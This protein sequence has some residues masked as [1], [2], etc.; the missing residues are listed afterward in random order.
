MMPESAV[1]SS[2]IREWVISVSSHSN[3]SLSAKLLHLGP[4]LCDPVNC[5]LPGSFVCGILQARTLE[6]VA[7]PSSRGSSWPRGQTSIFLLLLHWQVGSLPPAPPYCYHLVT[8]LCLTLWPHGLHAAHQAS[9]SFT[10]SWNLLKLMSIEL[11]M[12]SNHLILC[13][14]SSPHALNLSQHQGLF[15]WV[16]SLHQVAKALELQ[17][18]FQH[19][20]FRQ[21]FRVDFL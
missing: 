20:S 6:W 4:T 11:M 3:L 17:F 5:S 1:L 19:Q 12:P 8:Q 13:Q 10:V 15:Q 14:L 16:S 7:V 2:C 21:I 9:L 18:Q